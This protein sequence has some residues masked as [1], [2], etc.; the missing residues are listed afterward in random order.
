MKA[1]ILRSLAEK[2]ISRIY[3]Y[4]LQKASRE[5]SEAFVDQLESSLIKIQ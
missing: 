2:D 3:Y 4:Y 5:T 1:L